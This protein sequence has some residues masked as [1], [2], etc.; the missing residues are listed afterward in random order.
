MTFII[1]EL[2]LCLNSF[3]F[4]QNINTTKN[5]NEKIM[6]MINVDKVTALKDTTCSAK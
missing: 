6:Y 4:V 3:L 5:T 2:S 1:P